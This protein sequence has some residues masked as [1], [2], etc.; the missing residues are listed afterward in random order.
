MNQQWFILTR[1]PHPDQKVGI[2][3]T[4]RRKPLKL[5]FAVTISRTF[6]GPA[7]RKDALSPNLEASQPRRQQLKV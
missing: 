1:P 5:R 3:L 2:Q 6:A 4:S 7:A